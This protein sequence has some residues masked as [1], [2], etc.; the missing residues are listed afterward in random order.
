MKI[1]NTFVFG[2][3]GERWILIW[4]IQCTGCLRRVFLTFSKRRQVLRQLH[5]LAVIHLH[6]NDAGDG[7]AEGIL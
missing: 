7:L 5:V 6:G 2:I 4:Q 3:G 1:P